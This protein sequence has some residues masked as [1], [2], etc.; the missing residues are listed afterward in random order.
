MK[1]KLGGKKKKNYFAFKKMLK[2]GLYLLET[3]MLQLTRAWMLEG[4]I[5]SELEYKHWRTMKYIIYVFI[6]LLTIEL[7]IIAWLFLF[8]RLPLIN[9]FLFL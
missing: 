3:K 7:F 9:H 6:Y 4:H 5:L 2:K 1:K 8:L